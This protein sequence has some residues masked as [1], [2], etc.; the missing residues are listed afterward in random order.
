MTLNKY[1][2]S[3]QT[4]ACRG[5]VFPRTWSVGEKGEMTGVAVGV[6]SYRIRSSVQVVESM[7]WTGDGG[8]Y[9]QDVW[10]SDDISTA[11]EPYL[12]KKTC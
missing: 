5:V 10:P 7:R 6:H 1:S 8:G 12:Y 3:G 11:R 4:M 9:A 2:P